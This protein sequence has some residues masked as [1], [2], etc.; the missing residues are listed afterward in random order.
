M[1]ASLNREQKSVVGNKV[2]QM[3]GQSAGFRAMPAA[4][5][6]K[7][8]ESTAQ[9]VDTMV[10]GELA[11]KTALA[12]R[13][14][15]DPY[16]MPLDTKHA[17][18]GAIPDFGAGVQKGVTE[19]ARMVKEIDFPAFVGALIENVF[20]AI[21]KSS[22]EQMRAYGEMVASVAKSLNDFKD[23]N[24][25]ENQARDHLVSKY[26]NLMQININNGKPEVA[27]KP[28]A[29]ALDLPDF[30]KDFPD[31][32]E[33]PGDLDTQTIED[34]LIPAARLD[35]A[36]GRQKLLA[37][38][39]LMGI[40]RIVVTDG[41]INAKLRFTFSAS[42]QMQRTHKAVDYDHG[43]DATYTGQSQY[44]SNYDQGAY[45]KDAKGGEQWTGG[46][47]YAKGQNQ[48]TVTPTIAVTDQTDTQST[49]MLQAAG[50]ISGEVSVNFKSDVV[51][52]E[53]LINTDQIQQLNAAQSA[54]RGAPAPGAPAALPA[55]PAPTAAAPAP[56]TQPATHA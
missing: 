15:R 27:A 30:K 11:A 5:R 14:A 9:I 43:F 1:T 52:L 8:F 55:A 20:H 50:S 40:N 25:T 32:A 44:E 18:E 6:A 7:I 23:D 48:Y 49:S 36:R 2:Q 19:A 13:R 16:A 45:A 24:V 26:P 34:T 39:I 33:N 31:L 22:I 21:V 56:A 17:K 28:G 46:T 47:G 41:K 37:T 54:G 12:K 4:D 10:H 35:L 53:K 29:N 42:D 38:V 3:L 51:P